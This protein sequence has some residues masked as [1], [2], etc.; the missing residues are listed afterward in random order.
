M[1][2]G[3]EA[4]GHMEVPTCIWQRSIRMRTPAM[5][6]SSPRRETK[7][8]R[9][10]SHRPTVINKMKRPLMRTSTVWTWPWRL[11]RCCRCSSARYICRCLRQHPVEVSWGQ[12]V[13][14]LNRLPQG[15]YHLPRLPFCTPAPLSGR[16]QNLLATLKSLSGRGQSP[17][18]ADG[19]NLRFFSSACESDSPAARSTSAWHTP[20]SLAPHPLVPVTSPSC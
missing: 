17:L 5:H 1:E 7:T 13:P 16:P 19:K 2:A 9:R 3:W 18:P 4:G 15:Q 12:P 14:L 20:H 6:H 8:P 11:K 10:S